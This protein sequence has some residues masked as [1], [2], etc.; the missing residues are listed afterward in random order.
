MS[1]LLP[2]ATPLFNLVSASGIPY[3]GGTLTFYRAG[4]TTPKNVYKDAG[5][6]ASWG[7]SPVPIDPDGR[8]LAY[9]NDD[10]AYDVVLKDA[11]GAT[12]YTWSNV[13][14]TQDSSGTPMRCFCQNSIA[15]G[16]ANATWTALDFNVE[17]ID[18]DGVHSTTTNVSQ[19]LLPAGSY[20]MTVGV[21]FASDAVGYRAARLV[22]GGG[23][24]D[25]GGLFDVGANAADPTQASGCIQFEL[26]VATIVQ[27]YVKQTSGGPL[28]TGDNSLA[29]LKNHIEFRKL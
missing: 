27:V 21:S 9:L 16:V 28:N 24:T 5:K 6:V 4:T 8:C 19:F 23:S 7:L 10:E 18:T 3:V 25:M 17:I 20:L 22:A 13:V 29:F 26:S 1:L 2:F 15:Q 11:D 14:S 12:V